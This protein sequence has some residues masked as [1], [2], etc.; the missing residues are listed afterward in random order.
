[1][2]YSTLLHSSLVKPDLRSHARA[3]SGHIPFAIWLVQTLKPRIIVELGT[4]WGQSYFN[5]CRAVT[6]DKLET[7]TYAVDTWV[8]DEH[9]GSY[10][11]EVFADV[12]QHNQQ[13]YGTI[14][15]LLRMTFDEA[16]GY[17]SDG[18]I[19]LLH[20]D[21]LHTYEAVKHDFETWL[22]KLTPAAVV[23][24]HDTNVRERG[25]GVWRLWEE[26]AS[27]YPLSLEFIH[28]HGLGV[29]QLAAGENNFHLDWLDP[30]SSEKK[31]LIKY[32][33]A[34]GAEVLQ[35]YA[36]ND[37][38]EAAIAGP[39]GAG[40][41]QRA[42]R[43]LS[44]ELAEHDGLIVALNQTMAERNAQ[45]AA[46]T[47]A[48]AEREVH[49]TALNRTMA[50][51]DVQIAA[52]T[53][54]VA[55]RDAQISRL[56]QAVVDSDAQID[57]LKRAVLDLKQLESES[58][59]RI[60]ALLESTSW[61]V[62]APL[63]ALRTRSEQRVS[64]QAPKAQSSTGNL[65]GSV[66]TVDSEFDAEFYLS[67]YPDIAASGIDA[68]HHYTNYGYR[69]GRL[70]RPPV[71]VIHG[72]IEHLDS[73][74]ST[75]LVVSHEA[76][77]TGAPILALHIAQELRKK[78]NVIALV[79]GGGEL[80][81]DYIKRCDIVIGPLEQAHNPV[82]TGNVLAKLI[83][84]IASN[85]CDCQQYRVQGRSAHPGATLCTNSLSHS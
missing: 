47:Q 54:T 78:H 25:F 11:E 57:A 24:F 39:T 23:L 9:A 19:D 43:R 70:G 20:I 2:E 7:R 52:L 53:R 79:L 42:T 50:E 12:Q 44:R 83:P 48:M 81:P 60:S 28:S 37:L 21:G 49:I 13:M 73:A 22:P 72:N 32:F 16:V 80:I 29:L 33:E 30:G 6:A 58:Q 82:I 66:R 14:S 4:H 15:N 76:S 46:L 68:Q 84:E 67:A 35:Q 56:D 31:L 1:M 75:V 65:V 26:L 71:P 64:R 38:R 8:G 27:R 5:F 59:T 17:F 34:R 85:I 36:T 40:W 69:E 18:S 62:T 77:R 61:R 3:W 55:E 45:I 10:G 51:R 41:T 74:K 63:R